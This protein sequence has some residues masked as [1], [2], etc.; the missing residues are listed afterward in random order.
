[1]AR[2]EDIISDADVLRV[3]AHAN[4]GTM[5]PREV[6]ADGVWKYSMGYSGGSTQ[7]AILRE[8]GLVTKP[9]GISYRADLTE[10]GKRYLRSLN[11]PRPGLI[12]LSP[13][14]RALLRDAAEVLRQIDA[15]DDG[16]G[17][18]GGVFG[19]DDCIRRLRASTAA[20]QAVLPPE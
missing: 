6:L 11:P 9:R 17:N 18:G 8:H 10:K 16:L 14:L 19:R 13:E 3:H 4:F 7:L 15:G 12:D 20:A 2:P 5:T 1:M